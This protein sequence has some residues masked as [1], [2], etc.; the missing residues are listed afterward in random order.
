M[1]K[2][3][4]RVSSIQNKVTHNIGD[5]EYKILDVRGCIYIHIFIYSGSFMSK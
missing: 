2:H 3:Y 1:S 4:F 5:L